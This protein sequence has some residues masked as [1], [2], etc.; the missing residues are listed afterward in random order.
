MLKTPFLRFV[1]TV[2]KVLLEA[3]PTPE[4]EGF[5]RL[6]SKRVT[7]STYGLIAN[8]STS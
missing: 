1:W 6:R 4:H 7:V 2:H 3:P 5:T 8:Y